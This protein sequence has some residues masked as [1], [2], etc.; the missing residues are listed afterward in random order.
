[1]GGHRPAVRPIWRAGCGERNNYC[2]IL[3]WRNVPALWVKE[4]Q[5][6]RKRR[7]NQAPLTPLIRP[8]RGGIR[9]PAAPPIRQAAASGCSATLKR[10]KYRRD[11]DRRHLGESGERR[12]RQRGG[13]GQARGRS[14]KLRRRAV[15]VGG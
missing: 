6:I 4:M 2:R 10:V 14:G 11:R 7:T 12:G 8:G 15:T 13:F 3:G 5:A 9:R 1:M